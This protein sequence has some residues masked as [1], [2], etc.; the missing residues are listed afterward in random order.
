MRGAT[1]DTTHA[2]TPNPNPDPNP[3]PNPS[4]NPNPNP[5]PRHNPNPTPNPNHRVQFDAFVTLAD[6]GLT[7]YV[8]AHR[9]AHA[10]L[11]WG[12]PPPLRSC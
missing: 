9:L 5:N 8:S 4:P 10:C 12:G 3:N 2:V 7:S 11:Q 1:H 6:Y